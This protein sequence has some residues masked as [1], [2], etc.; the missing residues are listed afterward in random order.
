VRSHPHTSS[1]AADLAGKREFTID[2]TVKETLRK[3][4]Q[5]KE[6][7]LQL[8]YSLELQFVATI[9]VLHRRSCCVRTGQGED[10]RSYESRTYALTRKPKYG[11]W[12]AGN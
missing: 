9:M 3:T 11:V 8:G 4:E 6:G 12:I 7:L 1:I 10:V 5:R 2:C